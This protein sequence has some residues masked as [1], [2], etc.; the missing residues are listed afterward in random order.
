M[1]YPGRLRALVQPLRTYAGTPLQDLARR[2]GLTRLFGREIEAIKEL[3]PPLVP[4]SFID[5]LPTIT[6]TR[7]NRRS[8][9]ALL[10][11]AL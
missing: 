6:P 3:L 4:E 5:L 11:G 8:R 2:S 1:A 10:L 7:T 9:M